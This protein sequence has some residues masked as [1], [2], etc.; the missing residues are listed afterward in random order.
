V[1]ADPVLERQT[2]AMYCQDRHISRFNVPVILLHRLLFIAA[3]LISIF[4]LRRWLAPNPS[5]SPGADDK[6]CIPC[7]DGATCRR[8]GVTC[9]PG[10]ILSRAGCRPKAH[11]RAYKW[12][13]RAAHEIASRDG[14]CIELPGPLSVD[15]FA[16]LFPKTN[17]TFL[18]SEPCFGI[19]VVNGT[20]R[21]LKPS[22]GFVCRLIAGMEANP[23]FFGFLSVASFTGVFLFCI[24][25]RN[26]AKAKLARKIAKQVRKILATTDHT[27]YQYDVKVQM[28]VKYGGVDGVWKQVVRFVERDPHVCVGVAGSRHETYWMWVHAD[29]F[30]Q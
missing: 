21:S 28:R 23:D 26:L 25:R 4:A 7:P 9:P 12:A 24:R 10:Q 18:T 19:V 27:I 17:I 15:D 1:I 2:R 20:V 30:T 8:G 6:A 11:W 29:H 16:E 5:C 3:I 13:E 22:L 14:D